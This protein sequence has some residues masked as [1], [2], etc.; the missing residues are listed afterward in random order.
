M[1]VQYF[2]FSNFFG[3]DI[4]NYP[5]YLLIGIV[6]FNYMAEATS[7]AMG[8]IV[9]NASLI[10]KVY[11]PKYI[12]PISRI[13][14]SGVNCLFSVIA[15]YVVVIIMGLKITYKHI[16]ILLGFAFIIIFITGVS[17]LLSAI[18]VYFRD[19]QFLYSVFITLWTYLTPV[20]YADTILTDKMLAFIK[21]NPMYHFIRYVR[22]IILYDTIPDIRATFFCFIFA[23]VPLGIGIFVFRKLENN[24]ILYI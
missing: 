3:F 11:V 1:L 8:S 24:F 6:M 7:Q 16:F 22:T 12:Y 23:V 4:E 19:T 2:V 13:L 10:N 18:M 17:L 20:F 14:S 15:L 21:F 5:V 9:E